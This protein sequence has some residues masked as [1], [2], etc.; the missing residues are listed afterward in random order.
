[1]NVWLARM[2]EQTAI[3]V[4]SFTHSDLRETPAHDS[5][6]PHIDCLK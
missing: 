3:S 6:S 5:E 2:V 4:N 1:M